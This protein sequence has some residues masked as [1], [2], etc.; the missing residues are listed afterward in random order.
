[1]IFPPTED[2]N[3]NGL[4]YYSLY[5]GICSYGFNRFCLELMASFSKLGIL[6]DSFLL[7]SIP[8]FINPFV[9]FVLDYHN[10]A[11]TSLD[12]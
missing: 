1:M 4:T 9:A 11:L 3:W 8:I 7:G 10:L 5:Y 2:K 6:S 12:F